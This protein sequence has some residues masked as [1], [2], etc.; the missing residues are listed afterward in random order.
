MRSD[1]QR[2]KVNKVSGEVTRNCMLTRARQISRVLTVIYDHE[3]RPFGI[4]APQFTLLA[5]ITE[6]GPVS[7]S[8]LG[9]R[10]YQDRTTMTRNLPPLISKGLV[11][12]D[13]PAEGGRRRPLSLTKRAQSCCSALP[14]HGR[15]H[16][17]RPKPSWERL[18]S[19][20]SWASQASCRGA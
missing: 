15:L 13:S 3:L 16:K 20:R 12:E 18:V 9:R 11:S 4:N 19:R 1:E 5:L 14:L 2:K 17:Q 8:D 6:L 7:R 10:N